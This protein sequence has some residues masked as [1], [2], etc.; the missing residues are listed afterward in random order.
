M[1]I[2]REEISSIVR[3]ELMNIVTSDP[4]AQYE[5]TG[6]LVSV[7]ALRT[8][9]QAILERIDAQ[10]ERID[11]LREDFNRQFAQQAQRMD[12]FAERT[13]RLTERLDQFERRMV[14]HSQQIGRLEATVV[15][16]GSRWSMMA[17]NAFREGLIGIL[18]GTG[19]DVHHCRKVDVRG[20]VFAEPDQVEIDVV[21]RDGAHTLIEIKSSA[22][23]G[24][25]E[26]FRRK[27][28]FYEKEESVKVER[29]IVISPMFGPGAWESARASGMETYTSAYDVPAP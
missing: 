24:D 4:K 11:A 14:E 17:E 28:S 3:E 21:I 27:L 16:L 15:G 22:S 8:D 12:R 5:L 18:E 23:R 29:A 9:L 1:G 26:H 19:W 2:T 10:G 20:M 25:V 7:F 6:R 13:D